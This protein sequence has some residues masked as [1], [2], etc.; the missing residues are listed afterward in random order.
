MLTLGQK[1]YLQLDEVTHELSEC[2]P[3]HYAVRNS[4]R[5][6]GGKGR[7]GILWLRCRTD[8]IICHFRQMPEDGSP[9]CSGLYE[10][11]KTHGS[12]LVST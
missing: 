1:A 7:E 12:S 3:P 11:C 6:Y 4:R 2:V 10:F 5:K 8:T 9:I